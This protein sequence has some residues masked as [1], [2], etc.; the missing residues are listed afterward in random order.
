MSI[1]YLIGRRA[2]LIPPVSNQHGCR[3]H[4]LDTSNLRAEDRGGTALLTLGWGAATFGAGA[5]L[6]WMLSSKRAGSSR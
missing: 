2:R 6:G 4:G 3:Q 5:V 1:P